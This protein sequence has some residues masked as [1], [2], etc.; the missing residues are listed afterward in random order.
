MWNI[1]GKA[2]TSKARTSKARSGKAKPTASL[3]MVFIVVHATEKHICCLLGAKLEHRQGFGVRG[4][5]AGSPCLRVA[6][7]AKP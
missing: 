7:K 2:R 5:G 1:A 6:R 4:A 3:R